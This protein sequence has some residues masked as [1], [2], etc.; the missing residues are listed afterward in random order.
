MRKF[1]NNSI[2]IFGAVLLIEGIF[3]HLLHLT[4][5]FD[6][7]EIYTAISSNPAY[8]WGYLV[9]NYLIVDVHPPLH[10]FI[11]W[12]WNH[13]FPY[14]PEW[15][16][17]LPS[18]LFSI[19][20]LA[21]AWKYFPKFIDPKQRSIARWIFILLL[22]FD[23]TLIT[24]S[25]YLRSYA[26]LLFLSV[27]FTF[28]YLNIMQIIQ[29]GKIIPRLWWAGYAGLS[30]LLC[31]T[32]YFGALLFGTVSLILFFA[33]LKHKYELRWFIYIPLGVF[34]CFLPWLWPN[35][36]Q[37]IA[38]S[39]FAGDWWANS[40]FSI[41]DTPLLEMI[42][43]KANEFWAIL[44]NN[45][46]GTIHIGLNLFIFLCIVCLVI[47]YRKYRQIPYAKEMLFLVLPFL[48]AFGINLFIYKKIFLL[49]FRYFIPFF[50]SLFLFIVLLWI[51]LFI[52]FKWLLLFILFYC[53]SVFSTFFNEPPYD[54]N[55]NFSNGK[56]FAQYIMKQKTPQIYTVNLEGYPPHTFNPIFSYYLNT[57]FK[58]PIQ[59]NDITY[60]PVS[61]VQPILN[62]PSNTL[63]TLLCERWKLNKIAQQWN[64]TFMARRTAEGFCILKHPASKDTLFDDKEWEEFSPTSLQEPLKIFHKFKAK[65][66]RQEDLIRII[67]AGLYAANGKGDRQAAIILAI[68]DKAT[69][70]RLVRTNCKIGGWPC[71]FDPFYNAPAILVVLGNKKDPLSPYST[72]LIA[73]NMSMAAHSSGLGSVWIPR[74]A[75]EEFEQDEWKKLLANL[76]IQGKWE[77]IGHFAVGHIDNEQTPL[78]PRKENRVFWMEETSSE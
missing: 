75:K 38:R 8:N 51:P 10:N 53:I 27:P 37:N 54:L 62:D 60:L 49:M 20:A 46:I 21:I 52:R 30:I 55:R 50:P 14:G 43:W 35:C 7:D 77:G 72:N 76:N 67:D 16:A 45:R 9:K 11:M 39:K 78:S 44:C 58:Q 61:Q 29:Q 56:V 47:N 70:K 28:L 69:R 23:N 25:S 59:V 41:N 64:W 5:S 71:E 26:L 32:H 73:G 24:Q 33:A 6:Y 13:I 42:R 2:P 18:V 34:I 19:G 66:P 22:T 63:Y 65:P 74:G 48:L 17:R 1:F 36:L 15:I 3:L 31:Y 40:Y 12:L 57:Y 68:T 4:R